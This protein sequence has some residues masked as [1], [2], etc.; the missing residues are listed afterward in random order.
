MLMKLSDISRNEPSFVKFCNEY[1]LL[2]AFFTPVVLAYVGLVN[3][4]SIRVL[5]FSI[6]S[7]SILFGTFG[8][9]TS[10]WIMKK[11]LEMTERKFLLYPEEEELSVS[12]KW[13]KVFGGG[14]FYLPLISPIL[15]F[16]WIFLSQGSTSSFYVFVGCCLSLAVSIVV[17][18]VIFKFMR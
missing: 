11:F 16:A 6:L 14:K 4:D 12:Q 8:G 10:A 15:A 3:N 1:K 18:E 5:Y 17:R 2:V 9:I 7:L 13:S